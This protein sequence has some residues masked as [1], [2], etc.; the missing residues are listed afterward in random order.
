[1]NN[2]SKRIANGYSVA[3]SLALLSMSVLVMPAYGLESEVQS[4]F[5]GDWEVTCDN[6]HT[7]RA[8][9]YHN[10]EQ[11]N[12]AGEYS[13]VSVIFTRAAGENAKVKGRV[14]F[15]A[16]SFDGED[17]HAGNNT[18]TLSI[19]DT[20]QS[21]LL[22]E[23]PSYEQKGIRFN[24]DR[25][26]TDNQ[27][28][29]LLKALTMKGR[30]SIKFDSNTGDEWYLS[31]KGS[32]AVLLKMDDYQGLVETP[33]AI[34]KK[35]QVSKGI[36]QPKQVP[37]ISIPDQPIPVTTAAD[38]A[39]ATDADFN[40]R[41][42][43]ALNNVCDNVPAEDQPLEL[44]LARLT[45]NKLVVSTMCWSA[46]YNY[47]QA[48]WLVDDDAEIE[49]VLVTD[50]A[51]SYVNGVIDEFMRGRGV[52]DCLSARRYIWNGS[53]FV[54]ADSYTTG[55]CR[56]IAPGGAWYIPTMVSTVINGIDPAAGID[57]ESEQAYSTQGMVK[58]A[59]RE[60]AGLEWQMSEQLAEIERFSH[61]GYNT[62]AD[63]AREAAAAIGQAQ[64]AWRIFRKSECNAQQLSAAEGSLSLSIF[65]GCQLELT[66]QRIQ[67]LL[68]D[69]QTFMH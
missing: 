52:G 36:V 16:L 41:I 11:K 21:V 59:Q 58:C 25:Q 28:S 30:V 69:K 19:N 55:A 18:I 63:K 42:R 45:S 17:K 39:L 67:Q 34:V 57:C 60:L 51:V 27:V 37:V 53:E 1:M 54:L 50:S 44:E 31:T 4:F 68:S 40:Q 7:C 6:T 35:G 26:L 15:G 12:T 22:P 64:Q 66:K 5:H 56:E 48:V 13:P 65:V 14:K 49:P 8:V 46:A 9:G 61:A 47:G 3:T 23:L 29:E 24:G 43:T 38:L 10:P 62:K 20:Y 2:Y 33:F 32:T